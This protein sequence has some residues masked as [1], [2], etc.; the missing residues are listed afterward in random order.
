MEGHGRVRGCRELAAAAAASGTR[1][2]KQPCL[3]HLS[4]YRGQ[5]EGCSL[6]AAATLLRLLLLAACQVHLHVCPI[7]GCLLSGLLRATE[8]VQGRSEQSHCSGHPNL[9]RRCRHPARR[10]GR[11]NPRK[12]PARIACSAS[13]PHHLFIELRTSSLALAR[14]SDRFPSCVELFKCAKEIAGRVPGLG[15]SR[16]I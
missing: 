15:S 9:Q 8:T 16:T 13:R 2:R 11:Q 7:A 12:K 3:P 6:Q 5:L 1:R 14:R 10:G 4:F